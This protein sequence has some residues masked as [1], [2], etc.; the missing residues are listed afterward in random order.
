MKTKVAL[1]GKGKWGRNINIK[2]TNLANLVFVSGK[3]HN[4][5]NRIKKEKVQWVFIA[6][7]N[8]THYKI[9]K[10]AE[11]LYQIIPD[12]YNLEDWMRAKLSQMSDD[13]SEVY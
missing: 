13:I 4:F 8:R 2:L 7:P 3:K 6:T 11:K 5:M 12:G 10:Y 9:A 1:I